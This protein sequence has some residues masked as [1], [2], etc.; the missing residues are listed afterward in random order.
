V[1]DEGADDTGRATPVKPIPKKRA[2]A[3][4][5]G[6]GAAR[7][8]PRLSFED[9]LVLGA[10][11][12]EHG[13]GD[14]VRRLTLFDKLGKSSESGPSRNLVT[15]SGRYGITE[16]G[17][18]AEHL[19]LTKLGRLAT[20]PEASPRERFR[21]RFQLAIESIPVFKQLY[22]SLVGN[23]VPSREVLADRA[24]EFGVPESDAAACVDGFLVNAKFVGVLKLLSGAERIVKLDHALDEVPATGMSAEASGGGPPAPPA[25]E[26]AGA[27]IDFGK[28]AFFIAPIGDEGSESRDHSDMMLGALVEKALEGLSLTVVRADKIGKPGMISA[29]VIEYILK[30]A[31]VVADL[32]YHN[33]NVFYEL[34]HRHVTDLP[35]VHLIRAE[36]R[37]PFD[38]A[39]FR[40]IT[41]DTRNKYHLVARLD[42]YRSEIASHVRQALDD[43]TGTTSPIRTFHPNLRLIVS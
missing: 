6:R 41:I 29:Q 39:G 31:V 1:A 3:K 30:S 36:D 15:E 12:Q 4:R 13:G 19:S 10:A 17:Y 28:V 14:R 8:F 23:K 37:I 42:S 38:I 26:P 11:I 18:S 34:A 25:G 2:N 22:E 27:P 21:A 40:T 32:S 43:K 7:F 24:I 20:D 35:T 33:P 9:A 16:G 5:R